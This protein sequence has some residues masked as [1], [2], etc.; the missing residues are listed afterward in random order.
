MIDISKLEP[1]PW[2]GK[3]CQS[4]ERSGPNHENGKL[5]RICATCDESF[6][7]SEGDE[8]DAMGNDFGR[9][10]F[11]STEQVIAD[12]NKCLCDARQ[13]GTHLGVW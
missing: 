2:C 9:T 1:C 10:F 11:G 3:H 5:V 13:N 12:W 7:A 8:N 4:V 6:Q